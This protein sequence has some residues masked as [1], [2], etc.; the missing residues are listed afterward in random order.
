MPLIG[1]GSDQYHLNLM[2]TSKKLMSNIPI[3]SLILFI[4][5]SFLIVY[6][7]DFELKLLPPI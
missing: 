6:F 4:Y 5:N 7:L 3:N 1:I 2:L